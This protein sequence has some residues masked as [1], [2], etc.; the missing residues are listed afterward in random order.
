MDLAE[1]L[2]TFER[3]LTEGDVN[4]Y[5]ERAASMSSVHVAHLARDGA[6]R[7]AL[8]RPTR[9]PAEVRSSSCDR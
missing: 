3:R 5:R 2:L 8:H 6:W 1:T 4:G 7:F 9:W